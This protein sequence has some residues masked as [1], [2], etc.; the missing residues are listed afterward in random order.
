MKGL[1]VC[2]IEFAEFT[3]QEIN[4]SSSSITTAAW[5]QAAFQA[6]GNVRSGCLVGRSSC[7]SGPGHL[8]LPATPASSYKGEG[9]K[10][11]RPSNIISESLYFAALFVFFIFPISI[12]LC[13]QIS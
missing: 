3:D 9:T 5:G 4:A 11:K 12:F 13:T 7:P 6:V 8:V 10:R 1:A 2:Y